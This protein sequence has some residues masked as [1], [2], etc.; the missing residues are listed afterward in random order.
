MIHKVGVFV[1]KL[2]SLIDNW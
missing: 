1:R 2:W